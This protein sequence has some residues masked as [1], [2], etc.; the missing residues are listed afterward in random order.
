MTEEVGTI[1]STEETPT[2]EEF[3]FTLEKPVKK[4]QFVE[5]DTEEGKAVARVSSIRKTNIFFNNAESVSESRKQG[6]NL[7]KQF[8]TEDREHLIG[9]GRTLGVYH[10]SGLVK[11]PSFPPSP[12]TDVYK[13]DKDRLTDFLGL[14]KDSGI[15]IGDIQHQNLE[16]R[17]DMTKLFQKHLAILA[18]S[19][20]GKSYLASVMLEELLDRD[21]E[22]GQLGVVVLDPHGEY[23]GFAQDPQYSDRVE[24][25]NA[26]DLQIGMSSMTS[27]K[28]AYYFSDV[29]SPQKREMEKI[30]GD[31]KQDMKQ[32]KGVYGLEEV[33]RRLEEAEMPKKT[34]QIWIDRLK[35][36]KYMDLFKRYD[37]PSID[38]IEPGKM[39]VLDLSD[40]ID[41]KKKQIIA[42]YFSDKLFKARRRGK[43]PPYFF[44]VE[45]AHTFAPE[46]VSSSD[47][48]ARSTIKKI[49]REGR[50]FHASLGLISQRPV[51]LSTT[52]LSQC[53]THM[54]LRV[55]N[56]NDLDR[57]KQS[58]EGITSDVIRSIPGLRVGECIVVG[59]AVDYPAFV[60][61]RERKSEEFDTGQAIQDAALEYT[62]ELLEEEQDVDAFM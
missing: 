42:A 59:E 22:E 5:F 7:K 55:T 61:V 30:L 56:P 35:R 46:N 53:N 38:R 19:G 58:S 40:V 12:G 51:G 25:Y 27:S 15:K 16:A 49:A 33:E 24:V 32:G 34:R 23:A 1:I 39:I 48:I 17:L 31:L 13:A 52:A 8:P 62:Q 10:S 11:R 54:I 43:I 21:P 47:A 9:R 45:E 2:S 14:E 6:V 37:N 41:Y 29:T 3:A 18:Q 4:E 44:L 50:K 20:A 57:I 36:M 26:S 60:S 28:L